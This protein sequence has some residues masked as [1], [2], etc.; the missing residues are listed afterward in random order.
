[1]LLHYC[2][3]VE[4]SSRNEVESAVDIQNQMSNS[5]ASVVDEQVRLRL[6]DNSDIIAF[7]LRKLMTSYFDI[8]FCLYYVATLLQF[9]EKRYIGRSDST[10]QGGK[11]AE[12][13]KLCHF[14]QATT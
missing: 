4:S 14:Y 11:Y 12:I 3:L 1:M 10:F 9:S 13:D 2:N 6:Y 7:D 8:N 5:D